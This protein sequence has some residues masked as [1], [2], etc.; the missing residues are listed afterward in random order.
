MDGS[1]EGDR[2][3]LPTTFV[4]PQ[5][6]VTGSPDNVQISVPRSPSH[7]ATPARKRSRYNSACRA[8]WWEGAESRRLGGSRQKTRPLR[9]KT[10]P[11]GE[12]TVP[13]SF[14]FLTV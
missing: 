6:F 11:P 7:W 5:P 10:Q 12:E 2:Q 1:H 14:R 8:R 4:F 9:V 3:P 13:G